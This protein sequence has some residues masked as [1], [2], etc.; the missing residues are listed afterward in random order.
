MLKAAVDSVDGVL[1]HTSPRAKSICTGK[2]RNLLWRDK[3]TA[4]IS[5][6]A[7]APPTPFPVHESPFQYF[8]PPH[9]PQECLTT[10]PKCLKVSLCSLKRQPKTKSCHQQTCLLL[11]VR[12]TASSVH[13]AG[14]NLNIQDT[15]AQYMDCIQRQGCQPGKLSSKQ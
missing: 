6:Q 8:A 7:I 12:F 4:L 9:R 13:K 15:G 1:E 14:H 2:T 11:S 5:T 10:A 3:K